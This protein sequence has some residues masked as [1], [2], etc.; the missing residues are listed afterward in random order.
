MT[1]SSSIDS[2]QLQG[3]IPFDYLTSA[4]IEDLTSQ[5]RE[6]TLG[7]GKILFKRGSEDYECHFL[8]DGDIDLADENFNI[9]KIAADSEDNYLALDNSSHIHRTSAI[10]TTECQFYS[11]NRDY[12]DLVTTWSQLSEDLEEQDPDFEDSEGLDW[13]DALLT[14]PLFTRIPAANIQKLLVRFKE[15]AVNIG[16][17]IVKEEEQGEE[18]YVIKNGRAIVSQ[19]DGHKEKTLAAIQT[20]DCFGEDA[21]IGE[22]AR[23]ATVTMASNGSLMVLDKVDFDELLKKP[24]IKSISMEELLIQM[25]EGDSGTVLIDVRRPQEFRHDRLKN[26]ENVPL[27][28]LREK[29]KSM[30]HDFHYVVCCDG[31]RRSEVA[32]YIMTESGFNAVCLIR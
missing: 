26:S 31:G 1:T 23:N 22:S 3:F 5:F 18:F 16:E 29:L 12:L 8:I 19:G 7:K 32:A 6:H 27:N 15:R 14:S 21:L 9:T 28:H 11:I 20:G 10:T 24:I 25:D 4:C 2:K 13:M 17:V 30:N